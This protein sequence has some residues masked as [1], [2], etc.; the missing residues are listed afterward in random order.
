[1]ESVQPQKN[2]DPPHY[3]GIESLLIKGSELYSGSRDT[4]IK[5]WDM[6]KA[7]MIC[8]A[9]NA[10]TGWITGLS[11]LPGYSS[12]DFI[13]SSSRDGCVKVWDRDLKEVLKVDVS[14]QPNFS[15]ES[16]CVNSCLVFTAGG[17]ASNN[18][19]STNSGVR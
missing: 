7:E 1:M 18:N 12:L 11:R 13:L 9:S 10:H 6:N 14:Q 2:L 19:N 3:D 4:C 17:S 16:L 15:V 5:R 8:C